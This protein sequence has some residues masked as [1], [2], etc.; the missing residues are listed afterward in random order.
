[1]NLTRQAI[2]KNRITVTALLLILVGGA[3]AYMHLPRDYDPGFII[4]TAR[5]V[6]YFPGASPER[7][8]LLVTDRLEKAIQ[9]IP[10]LDFVESDSKTGISVIM[11]NI[12]ERYKKMRPIWDDLRRKAERVA[13][14][15]PEGAIGPFVNDEFGD[16]F[17]IIIGITGDGFSYAELKDV[18]DEVRDEFLL[19][20]EV[21]KADIHG[22][23][24]ER[25]FVEYSNARLA[26]M[27]ISPYNLLRILESRNIIIPGGDIRVGRERIALEP[28]G[29]FDSIE[30]LKQSVIRIPGAKDVI[31]LGDIVHIYRGYIDPPDYIMRTSGEPS[32][33]LA[34]SLRKG[35]NLI[36][37]GEQVTAV[38]DRLQPMYPHGLEFEVI[39]FLPEEVDRK[40]ITFRNNLLQAIGVVVLVMLVTLGVRTGLIVASLIPASMLMA[41]LVMYYLN[42]GLDQMSLAS[43]IIALG[44]LVDNAIVMTESVMVQMQEGKSGIQ[45]ASA[46]ARELT[47][48]LLTSS[49][50]TAAA[51]LPIFLAKSSTGEYT[52]PLFKVV[53]ITLLCSWILSLTM[54]P[55][56]CVKFIRPG[57]KKGTPYDASRFYGVYR[58]MLLAALRHRLTAVFLALVLFSGAVWSMKYLP[59]IFFPPSDRAYFKA[60]L[61]L[62][63]G[64]A[65]RATE[66]MAAEVESYIEKELL[67]GPDRKEGVSH[68][69]VFIGRGGPRFILQHSPE[70]GSPG[71]ALFLIHVTSLD[72]IEPLIEKLYAHVFENFPD[73]DVKAE[74]MQNGP[75]VK[76][77]I[78][79][80]V[81]GRDLNT[82]YGL[83]DKVKAR[84]RSE[85]GTR[86]V[87]DD[88][89]RRTKKIMVKIDQ[90]R[91]QR[92]GVTSQ[93]I[94]VSLQTG[95]SGLELTEYREE[96]K[97]IPVML[98]TEA[99]YR[100]DMGKL[101]SLNVYVQATGKSVPLKQVADVE[102]EW[103]PAKIVRK[104]RL[105]TITVSAEL[106]PGVTADA[107]NRKV[108]PWLDEVSAGWGPG[109]RYE[110]GGEAEESA[111]ANASI[112]V[113]LPIAGFIILM[114]LVG[115]FNSIRKPL[116]ILITIPLGFIG[117]VIGLFVTNLY[118]GFMTLLGIVSLS[119]IVINNAIVLL[120]RIKLEMDENGLTPRRAVV[121]AAQ[122]RMRP[123]LLTS[124]TTA[125]GMIPLYF[126]GGAMWAPMAVA[127]IFGILF[128]T[129]L[130]LGLVPVMYA[131]FFRVSYRDFRY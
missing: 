10:E 6:T 124:A 106:D 121:E 130:T 64:A 86:S 28:S 43:L 49:L 42:I 104:D 9:E 34:V 40:I 87:K 101:E 77:P 18:A 118:F 11:V 70:A 108:V 125:L 37:L 110:L 78:E 103:Q 22:A 85:P 4:R 8:E 69:A 122:R 102:L 89:G 29:N 99:A 31:R 112:M 75:P 52:A 1:M 12:Q 53:T 33:G 19:L 54:T 66:D 98:R 61:E 95:L 55:L 63:E 82:L 65:I 79:I 56:L 88:W 46:S 50:T 51:F 7:V 113:Q 26:D 97:I 16:V 5:V 128:A 71:Y 21:A 20:G 120:E 48:P 73:V 96:D 67:A 2:Q 90:A 131:L 92:A 91:A 76:H 126:G 84:L 14:D 100:R 23:Q 83:V 111:K 39:N 36:R 59:V 80:R 44:M 32:L 35:G 17:G 58:G 45:A 60:E 129:L 30:D 57:K 114:M 93:D 27:G 38:L 119:G 72:R 25:V 41:L 81:S 116:I 94:A 62:P 68:W 123:I 115:Q 105:K 127:I 24:E 117:V 3:A 107:V 109:Y 15:L 47:V 74:K 13:P